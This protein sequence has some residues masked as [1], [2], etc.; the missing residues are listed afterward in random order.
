[1]M[2]GAAAAKNFVTEYLAADLPTRL[3]QYRNHLNLDEDSLP[4]PLLYL[5]YEPVALDHWPT[6]ITVA[7]SAPEFVRDDYDFNLNPEY[8]VRYNMRTYVWVKA[9]GSQE[10]TTMRDNLTM[11]VRSALLDYPCL[12]AFDDGGNHSVLIDEGTMREEY[13]DLTLIKGERVLAGAY[14]GYDLSLDEWITRS[15]VGTLDEIR[16]YT[17]NDANA[18]SAINED[19]TYKYKGTEL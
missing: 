9:D 2:Q 1:M 5:N 17:R 3:L 4:D 14:V 7:I 11:V 6:V 18:A 16:I 19:G 10:C 15:N 13:S 8:R 12:R